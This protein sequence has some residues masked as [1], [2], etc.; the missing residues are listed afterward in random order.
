[1][2]ICFSLS[3]HYSQ[4]CSLW[5]SNATSGDYQTFIFRIRN[6]KCTKWHLLRV[7]TTKSKFG[8]LEWPMYATTLIYQITYF[9]GWGMILLLIPLIIFWLKIDPIESHNLDS[10]LTNYTELSTTILQFNG[11]RR[12]WQTQILKYFKEL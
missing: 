8:Q 1:M 2:H 5:R 6:L 12:N 10:R 11:V 7:C 9:R 4:T 3:N